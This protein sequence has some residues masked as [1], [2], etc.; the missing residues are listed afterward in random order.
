MNLTFTLHLDQAPSA[1]ARR[2][3]QAV[4]TGLDAAAERL[5]TER[6][7]THTERS[8]N[9][10][11]ITGGVPALDGSEVRV[12]GTDRL[13]VLEIAVPW[14]SEDAGSSKLWAAN[15]FASVVADQVCRAA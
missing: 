15:R 11:R 14:R 1:V 7:D 6:T 3:N 4:C 12:S 8:G 13:T 9:V 5:Q 2:L 10:V